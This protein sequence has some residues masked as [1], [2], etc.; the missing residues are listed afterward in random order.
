MNRDSVKNRIEDPMSSISFTEFTYQL[1]Q[2]YDFAHL[3]KEKNCVLQMGG[4]DQW[5]NM[6]AGIDLVRRIHGGEAHALTC[7]LITK[8]DGTK[9]GKSESGNIWLDPNLT[10]PFEFFQFWN[11]LNDEDAGK[12]IS[13]FTLIS[14]N[15]I[16]DM[17]KQHL[18]DP[19]VKYLQ[20]KLAEQVTLFVHGRKALDEALI[21]TD[22]LFN[23][24]GLDKIA[25][26]TVE[27]FNR[28]FSKV[29]ATWFTHPLRS[30]AYAP[31]S[32]P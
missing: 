23:D 29:L 5:G 16:E 20:H 19:K 3:F 1:I 27:Q 31:T 7:P 4:S 32:H 6:T 18:N 22:F 21:A 2:A 26:L 13:I 15:Q 9:F 11:Q 8:A 17:K 10:S 24:A 28:I 12:M 30:S 14:V 25:Q